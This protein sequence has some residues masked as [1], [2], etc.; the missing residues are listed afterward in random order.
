MLAAEEERRPTATATGA[1]ADGDGGS[2]S[3]RLTALPSVRQLGGDA[4]ATDAGRALASTWARSGPS[5][6]TA[7]RGTPG[8]PLRSRATVSAGTPPVEVRTTRAAELELGV[9]VFAVVTEDPSSVRAFDLERETVKPRTESW[10]AKKKRT[11]SRRYDGWYVRRDVE[12]PETDAGPREGREPRHLGLVHPVPFRRHLDRDREAR[13]AEGLGPPP[14][15]DRVADLVLTEDLLEAEP[16][17][18]G[19]VE[20]E[21]LCRTRGCARSSAVLFRA[22]VCHASTCSWTHRNLCDEPLRGTSEPA[23]ARCLP[24]SS[25]AWRQV[26]MS[27]SRRVTEP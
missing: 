27:N 12:K 20:P 11:A 14:R 9:E 15:A 17:V 5:P 1:S 10:Q 24:G 2:L 6:A 13:D 23:Q 8:A 22:G 3:T 21:R 19:A 16:G 26:Q 25:L 7:S 4:L 18:F